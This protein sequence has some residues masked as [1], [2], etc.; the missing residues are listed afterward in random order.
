[1]DNPNQWWPPVSYEDWSITGVNDHFDKTLSD[2]TLF[3][4][5][6][7]DNNFFNNNS[8]YSTLY[9]EWLSF[10]PASSLELLSVDPLH[11]VE[12]T[13]PWLDGFISADSNAREKSNPIELLPFGGRTTSDPPKSFT[14]SSARCVHGFAL[15]GEGKICHSIVQDHPPLQN[16]LYPAHSCRFACVFNFAGCNSRFAHKDVW[17][18]HVSTQHLRRDIWVCDLGRCG[19]PSIVSSSSSAN[20]VRRASRTPVVFNRKDLFTQHLHHIHGVH[21]KSALE[22]LIESKRFSGDQLD[23]LRLASMKCPVAE[24]RVCFDGDGTIKGRLDDYMEHVAEHLE[25][26]INPFD[27]VTIRHENNESLVKWAL[28]SHII[29]L[30]YGK[31]RLISSDRFLSGAERDEE[32]EGRLQQYYS[33]ISKLSYSQHLQPKFEKR[34]IEVSATNEIEYTDSGYASA[35]NTDYLCNAQEIAHKAEVSAPSHSTDKIEDDTRTTYSGATTIMPE[36]YRQWISDVCKDI[37]SKL[38]MHVDG[39]T[40]ESLSTMLP[41]LIKI[42]AVKL[43]SDASDE[44]NQRIMHFVHKHHQCVLL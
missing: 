2:N 27:F 14:S 7:L 31:Y 16:H 33:D 3:D 30:V 11:S 37:H 15:S 17:K 4:N 9:D 8:F 32:V 24:C 42:L 20:N 13:D 23:H 5:N 1:M 21:S 44:F 28:N 41:E 29:E 25:R 19:M 12:P 6:L 26:M 38:E 34:G 43:G 22:N 18:R 36:T 10:E 40:R 39:K 35:L